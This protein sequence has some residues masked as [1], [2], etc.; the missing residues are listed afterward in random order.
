MSWL[1]FWARRFGLPPRWQVLC[2]ISGTKK[3]SLLSLFRNK[4]FSKKRARLERQAQIRD[5]SGLSYGASRLAPRHSRTTTSG[6]NSRHKTDHRAFSLCRALASSQPVTAP[7]IGSST[8]SAN[9]KSWTMRQRKAPQSGFAFIG[10]A[11]S[12]SSGRYCRTACRSSSASGIISSTVASLWTTGD[13]FLP[14]VK[15]WIEALL[16]MVPS[17]AMA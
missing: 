13:T 10:Y 1:P 15:I 14:S 11:F 4:F 5:S 8:A 7:R 3:A 6:G 2:L 12:C 17:S 16:P 9:G